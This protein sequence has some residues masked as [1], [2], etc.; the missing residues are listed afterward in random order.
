MLP[1]DIVNDLERIKTTPVNSRESF[2][3][4]QE[5]LNGVFNA[6]TKDPALLSVEVLDVLE[7]IAGNSPFS[8]INST[9]KGVH[10]RQTPAQDVCLHTIREF[11]RLSYAAPSQGADIIRRL[12]NMVRDNLDY[13]I[14]TEA[15]TKI[16]GISMRKEL[17]QEEAVAALERQGVQNSNS[18]IRSC[19]RDWLLDTSKEH[20]EFVPRAMA[21][22]IKGTEDPDPE[23]RTRAIALLSNRVKSPSCPDD[24]AQGLL[25]VFE[26][27]AAKAKLSEQYVLECTKIAIKDAQKRL[28]EGLTTHKFP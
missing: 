14:R 23:A 27:A 18:Y 21:A 26:R 15:L 10:H 11:R 28:K 2:W 25:S 8:D 7:S 1:Q 24:E 4:L 16:W 9:P 22:Q 20:E 5:Q 3:P 19:A 6:I 13:D 17:P 12:E